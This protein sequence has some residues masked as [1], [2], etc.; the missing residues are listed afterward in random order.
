MK[1]YFETHPIGV[2][3]YVVVFSWY[4]MEFAQLL[5]QQEWRQSATRVRAPGYVAAWAGV[6]IVTLVMLFLAPH[7]A[8]AASIGHGAAAFAVGMVMLAAGVALRVCSFLTLGQ[9]FTF[10]VRVSADQPVVSR[11]PYRVLRHPGYAGGLL[12]L[13][14]IGLLYGNWAGWATV[15]VLWTALIVWRIRVEEHALMTSLDASYRSY[16]AQHKRLVPLVW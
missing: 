15:A 9:Y 8:P 14:G 4:L 11:G 16:A 2:L 6:S 3:Y 13:L 12:A 5:R 7:I 10:S 1:P